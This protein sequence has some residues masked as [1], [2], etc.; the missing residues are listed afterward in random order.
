MD[1]AAYA[2]CSL[3]YQ[4][5]LV[6]TRAGPVPTASGTRL[7]AERALADLQTPLDTLIVAGGSVQRMMQAMHSDASYMLELGRVARLARRV[8][9]VCTGSFLLAQLGLLDGKRATT[10][11]A[12]LE[13]LEKLYPRVHVERDPIFTRDGN[14][15]TSAG[16]ST[17]IDL[18]LSLVREDHGAELAAEIARWLV[19]YVQRPAG[20]AQIS[21]PLRTQQADRTPI[22]DL[23]AWILEHPGAD[24][25]VP[26]LAARVGKSV[27]NF[28]RSFRRELSMT[29]AAY[30]EAVRVEVARRKI[31]IGSASLDEVAAQVGFGAVETLRRA[32]VRQ[33]GRPPSACRATG[34]GVTSSEPPARQS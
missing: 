17:A 8:V 30:V 6:G 23:K 13:F 9:S 20:Q 34:Q 22:T 14:V 28:A 21:V 4:V 33:T 7:Y 2:H 32:F 11:W 24:L 5:E 26:A 18:A 10:H 29:P 12:G 31:E 1:D 16:A 3:Q 27:R 25:S 15:Y 19:L